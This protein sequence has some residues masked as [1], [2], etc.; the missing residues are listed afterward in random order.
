LR[1]FLRNDFERFL[2]AVDAALTAPIELVIIGGSAAALRYGVTQ[3]TRDIDTFYRVQEALVVAARRARE[4]IGLDVPIQRAGIAD[5][6]CEFEDRFERIMPTLQ[7]L[8]VKVPEAHDLALMKAL[9]ADEH[10]LAAIEEIHQNSPLDL[11][12]LVGRFKDEM[13][14]AIGDPRTKRANFLAVVERLFPESVEV[15]AE[16]LP[17]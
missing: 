4:V 8:I 2:E 12:T 7:R 10:D 17:E 11:E 16:D 3:A 6:P 15:V 1:K 9:R 14:Q 13:A 5:P